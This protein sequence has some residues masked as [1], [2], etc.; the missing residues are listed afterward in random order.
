MLVTMFIGIFTSRVILDTLGEIDYGI[1]NVVGGFV[2]FFS[3]VSGTMTTATQR[4]LSFEIGKKDNLKIQRV[5]SSAVIIHFL[6]AII[7]LI[8]AESIG[9]WFLNS[10]MNFPSERCIAANWVFQISLF[11]FL[12]TIVSQPY[13]AALIAYEKMSAFAYLSIF[14]VVMK[15][16]IVY[17]LYI[18]PFD[19][20][21]M[22]AILLAVISIILRLIYGIYV[23][24]HLYAC[25]ITLQIDSSMCKDMFS[26]IG[27]NLIGALAY[28]SREQGVNIVLNMFFGPAV[29]AARGIAYQVLGKVQGF[30]NNFQLAF[31]PQIIKTYASGQRDV[32]N[33]LVFRSSKFSYL[34]MLLLS[35]PLIIEAP[36]ILNVWLKEVPDYTSIF[37]RLALA[38]SMLSSL[39]NPLISSM[40]ASGKVRDYQIIVG[41]IS[42]FTLPFAYLFLQLGYPPYSAMIVCLMM[43]FIC[44]VARL[45]LLKQILNFPIIE[46]FRDVTVRV[47]IITVLAAIIP[48]IVYIIIETPML[49]FLCV[50]LFSFLST[51]IIAFFLGLD[52]HE[53]KVISVKIRNKIRMFRK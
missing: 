48:C 40:H 23:K 13:N 6:L 32:M 31:T 24:R 51:S 34:L 39:S 50:C 9:V 5:F 37:M 18:S 17:M 42:L 41:G 1:Y 21:I 14:D 35:M 52:V 53:R 16:L 25:Q 43:E 46:F 45:L 33:K 12:V 19:R 3:V 47:L 38:T 10:H 20:L 29:N 28:I 22:Y 49:R 15:L 7:T 8:L 30:V 36:A 4:Y 44:H 2:M 27:W 11:T 26:F